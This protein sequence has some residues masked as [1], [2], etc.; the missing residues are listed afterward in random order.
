LVKVSQIVTTQHNVVN[1]PQADRALW[2]EFLDEAPEGLGDKKQAE[3]VYFVGCM[4]SFSPA[5]QEIPAALVKVLK[6]AGVDFAILGEEEWCCGFPLLAAGLGKEA[7]ALRE[8]NLEQ[9]HKLQA[10]QVVFTC[11]SCY[12]M[13]KQYYAQEVEV[14]HATELVS[15]LVAQRRLTL[16]PIE[17]KVTYHDPCDLGRNSGIYSPPRQVLAAIPGL[18]LRE[19]RYNRKQA[20]CC[21]GGGDLEIVDA[22]LV[23]KVASGLVD[24]IK[25]SGAQWVVTACQQCQRTIAEA[26]RKQGSNIRVCDILQLVSEALATSS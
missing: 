21:G 26:L 18:Q 10:K 4:A 5:V 12:H 8:H 11:P 22:E 13:W 14:L 7:L 6:A 25:A 2:A 9:I 24:E 20:L 1:F 19:M 15:R 16:K 17:R 3:V 23:A